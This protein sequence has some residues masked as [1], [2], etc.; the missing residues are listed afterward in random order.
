[1]LSF[2]N[3]LILVLVVGGLGWCAEGFNEAMDNPIVA[4]SVAHLE[5]AQEDFAARCENSMITLRE[6]QGKASDIRVRG[7]VRGSC[8]CAALNLAEL[9]TS[10][11]DYAMLAEFTEAEA[12]AVQNGAS[13]KDYERQLLLIAGRRG[14]GQASLDRQY[15]KLMGALKSC[16]GQAD[17][18]QS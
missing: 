15:A 14:L 18:E 1:M 12:T 5:P 8:R 2:R 4:A 6:S 3:G 7:V 16:F 17:E 13:N 11:T 9:E 10:D